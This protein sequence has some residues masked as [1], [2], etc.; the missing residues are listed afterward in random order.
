MV[1]ALREAH[2]GVA[3]LSRAFFQKKAPM[4]E[5]KVIVEQD[6]LLPVLWDVT[7]EEMVDL[8][9]GSQMLQDEGFKK[10][11]VRTTAVLA[12]EEKTFRSILCQK[13]AFAALRGIASRCHI[14]KINSQAAYTYVGRLQRA[15]H[16]VV[17]PNNFMPDI[18][19][20]NVVEAIGML[21][22][23]ENTLAAL[24]DAYHSAD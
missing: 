2:V 19:K 14:D 24:G 7:Y 22:E 17:K 10:K 4:R 5:L 12:V 1:E 6:N 3:I 20:R 16:K 18:S 23:V 21:Q 9:Q 13:V 8:C 11:V 15:L